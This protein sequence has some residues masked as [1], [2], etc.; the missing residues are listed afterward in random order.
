[1][2]QEVAIVAESKQFMFNV[3]QALCSV[4][5]AVGENVWVWVYVQTCMLRKKWCNDINVNNYHL[6]SAYG[7][8]TGQMLYQHSPT[9]AYD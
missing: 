1:M 5:Y 2:T 3:W 6:L 9:Y 8:S 7:V 4:S